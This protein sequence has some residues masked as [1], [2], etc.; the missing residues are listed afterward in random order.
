MPGYPD[1]IIPKPEHEKALKKRT[2]TNLYNERPFWLE[3]AHQAL[4]A[5]VAAAYGWSDYGPDT[6]QDEIPGRLFALNPGR[7]AKGR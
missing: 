7:G 5:D 4:D 1:R 2:L 6:A 3:N